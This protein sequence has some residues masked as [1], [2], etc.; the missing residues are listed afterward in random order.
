[1]SAHVLGL[2]VSS[3]GGAQEVRERLVHPLVTDGWTVGVTVTPTAADWLDAIGELDK[4]G[5]VTGLP[6]RSVPRLPGQESPHPAV[7]C[8]AVVPAS[9][10][11]VAKLALGVSDNQALTQVNEAIG[12]G[13]G[14]V[15]VFPRVNAAHARHPAWESH[16]AALRRAGVRLVYGE[17]VWPLHEP[18]SAPG[19]E[20]PWQAIL[21]E[22]RAAVSSASSR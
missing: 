22:I 9:A 20:L 3:A 2:V 13:L 12:L 10:N 7:D 21:S 17:E 16:I 19:R 11:T 18:R 6:L 8:Y 15:V 4:L 5:A 14:L 1:M